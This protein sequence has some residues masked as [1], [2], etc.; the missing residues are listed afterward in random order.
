MLTTWQNLQRDHARS[1]DAAL[2]LL[3]FGLSFSG[4]T[5]TYRGGPS[6]V[7][8]WPAM[9]LAGV[10]CAA[11]P[12]RRSHPRAVI[13]VTTGCAVGVAAL[14]YLLTVLLL[15]P[16]MVALFALAF[17]TDR[18]TANTFALTTIGL[19]VVTAI[20]AGPADEPLV[21][22]TIAPAAW[23]LLPTSLGTVARMRSEYLE[24]AQTRA[25]QAERTREEVARHR[26]AEERMRIARELHDVVA[27]H[28]ALANAQA[29]T[30]AHVVRNRPDQAQQMLAELSATTSSA[31]RELKAA[32]GLLRQASDQDAPLEPAPGLA[33]LPDLVAVLSAAGLDV[34]VTVADEGIPRPLS[35]GADL[36]AYR[37]VQ[38]ALTNVTKHAGTKEARVELAYSHEWLAITVTDQGGPAAPEPSAP[39]AGSGYGLIGMRERAHS[40][41]G[42]LRTGPRPGGGF[43]VT[44]EL[45]LPAHFPKE[46]PSS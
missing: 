17:R 36:T 24:A 6:S 18:R 27:H 37:I 7:S 45:P 11:L 46:D 13:A 39:A 38:E 23:L 41:G 5:I 44:A 40:V 31:L 9:L 19:L 35:P 2:V 20:A 3:L 14:G 12:W 4:S 15:G 8:W 22:K 28:L 25:E 33:R 34:T 10:S 1:L 26:V 29:G 30:A 16:L 32:V 21:L 43:Q 42:H